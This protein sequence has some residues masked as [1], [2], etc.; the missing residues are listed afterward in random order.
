MRRGPAV[1][2]GPGNVGCGV[3]ATSLQASGQPYVMV[4]R[5]DAAAARLNAGA[6]RVRRT[7]TASA[8]A[9]IVLR[10][11]SALTAGDPALV[12]VVGEASVLVVTVGSGQARTLA[13]DLAAALDRRSAPLPILVCDNREGAAEALRALVAEHQV[14]LAHT[15][16]FAGLMVD[17]IVNHAAGPGD[18]VTYLAEASG[19]MYVDRRALGGLVPDIAGMTGVDR[20]RSYLTRKRY[21]FSAGHAAAA[22]LGGL[23]GHRTLPAALRD[24]DLLLLVR[25]AMREGQEGIAAACGDDFAGGP[26]DVEKALAR[27]R[28]DALADSVTR[29]GRNPLRKLGRD[30]RIC[31]PARLAQ[32]AGTSTP[33]LA[34]VAAAALSWGATL[35]PDLRSR[36]ARLGPRA[37]VTRLTGLGAHHPFVEQVALAFQV[38]TDLGAPLEAFGRVGGEVPLARTG[39]RR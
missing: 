15:H 14:D 26:A 2:L 33:A 34:V 7:T 21:V 31:G 20:F 17:R 36:R 30:E 16:R 23:A 35:D 32:A 19:E 4:A 22:Y 10:P 8:D 18:S 27:F 1:V 12:D 6:V 24:D 29:V 3:V 39:G 11:V 9:G 5:T 13:P 28:D 25:A 38:L 37:L